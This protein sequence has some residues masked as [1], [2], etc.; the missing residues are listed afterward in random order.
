MGEPLNNYEAVRAAV[1][2]MVDSRLF[3]LRRSKVTVSTVGIVPRIL[4]AW[5]FL[6]QSF[7]MHVTIHPLP[8][9]LAGMLPH[10]LQ[11]CGCAQGAREGVAA[12]HPPLKRYRAMG[13][14]N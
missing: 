11:E 13:Q 2:M 6:C 12:K 3:G 1:G 4:Q 14:N 7:P 5:R 9:P 10:I 8:L